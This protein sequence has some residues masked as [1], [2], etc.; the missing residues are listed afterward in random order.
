[1]SLLTRLQAIESRRQFPNWKPRKAVSPL[2]GSM[3]P[4]IIRAVGLRGLE[5]PVG[6][7]TAKFCEDL[8]DPEVA[9]ILSGHIQDEENHDTQLEYLAEYLGAKI[10]PPEAD[11]LVDR[12]LTMECHPLLKK[13]VLEAGVF[14]PILGMMGVYA[15][16][17]LLVQSVRQWIS[18]DE[19]AHVA[20]SRLIIDHLRKNGETI[21]VPL[22]LLPLVRDTISYICQGTDEERWQKASYAGVST[23]KIEGGER[24]TTV[25]VP[26]HFTQETNLEILYQS[27]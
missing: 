1:M 3:H 15:K 19:S 6:E 17:D 14:F 22:R 10:V 8:G 16:S 23:G 11:E 21:V 27:R 25:A 7:W 18:S 4:I 20:S 2:T 26:E 12:W 13:M 9:A 24:M 5:I